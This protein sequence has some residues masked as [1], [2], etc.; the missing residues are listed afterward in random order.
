MTGSH[1]GRVSTGEGRH[2]DCI[3]RDQAGAGVIRWDWLRAPVALATMAKQLPDS[4]YYT[5]KT[6]INPF[7]SLGTTRQGSIKLMSLYETFPETL[8]LVNFYHFPNSGTLGLN[9]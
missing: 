1:D 7:P 8:G 9:I 4:C 3:M 6:L 5:Q 2:L